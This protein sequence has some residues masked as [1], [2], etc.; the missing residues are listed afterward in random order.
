MVGGAGGSLVHVICHF[1]SCCDL[2]LPVCVFFCPDYYGMQ[3]AAEQLPVYCP[4]PGPG[5]ITD[6]TG[7]FTVWEPR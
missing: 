7:L 6:L 3:L 2:G 1:V 4:H 5:I